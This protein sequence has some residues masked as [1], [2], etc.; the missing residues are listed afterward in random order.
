MGQG[1]LFEKLPPTLIL[2]AHFKPAEL[3]EFRKTLEQ[4]GCAVTD[5]IFQAEL[6]VTKLTQ[7]KRI[8]REIHELIRTRGGNGQAT[9]EMDIV[10]EKW[11]RQCLEKEELI[12]WPFAETTWRIARLQAI[13]PMSP[14]KRQRSPHKFV[15]PEAPVHKKTRTL[16]RSG[17]L[18]KGRPDVTSNPSFESA[19][20]EDPTSKHFRQP[21]QLS[22]ASSAEED[23]QFD[24][25]DVYSCRR[26]TPLVC[27]NEKFVKLLVE[28][29]LARELALYPF[30]TPY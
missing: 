19:S 5:S 18:N 16:S 29:K 30:H 4:N 9:K 12:D 27:P 23:E 15:V 17:S 21:S 20:S 10:K 24:I 26:K 1:K 22:Q 25:R 28:I 6:V 11:F 8:R 7:D 13:E 3:K 14:P 2:E